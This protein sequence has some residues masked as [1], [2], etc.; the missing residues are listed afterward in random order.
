MW[1]TILCLC[2]TDS[3]PLYKPKLHFKAKVTTIWYMKNVLI[4]FPSKPQ[5]KS[6]VK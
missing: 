5:R 1:V 4:K 3:K 2:Y 6:S